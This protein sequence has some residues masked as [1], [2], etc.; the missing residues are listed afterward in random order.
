MS[1]IPLKRVARL[2]GAVIVLYVTYLGTMFVL[3]DN[4]LFPAAGAGG[5]AWKA[6]DGVER[7]TREVDGAVT[8]ALFFPASPAQAKPAP[9]V[10]LGHG[11]LQVAEHLE[12]MAG[13]YRQLGFHVLIPEYRGFGRSTGEPSQETIVADVVHFIEKARARED[14][15]GSRVVYHGLSLGGAVVTAAAA[16]TPP[17]ALIL[18]STF[19]SVADLAAERLAPSFLVTNPFASVDVVAG[20]EIPIFVLHARDDEVIPYEHGVRLAEVSGAK[21][22]TYDAGGHGLPPASRHRE[23]WH[24]IR[25]FLRESRIVE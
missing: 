17:A 2:L 4:L 16:R 6:R 14:V 23:Y 19:T 13:P 11:N 5:E 1:R 8:E 10:V 15:D 24:S 9:L 20:L 21:F 18:Q 3:Q 22:I 7:W 12:H 25:D